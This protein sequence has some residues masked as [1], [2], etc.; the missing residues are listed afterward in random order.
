MQLARG[1]HTGRVAITEHLD[2]HGRMKGLVARTAVGISGMEGGQ[3][4][5]A[6]RIADEGSKVA[7]RQPI[8]QR[9]G[10]QELL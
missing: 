8:L 3:V 4:Q 6:E 2:H 10:Q 5:Q 1:K 9:M 7:L